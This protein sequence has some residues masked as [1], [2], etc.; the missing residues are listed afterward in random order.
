MGRCR[1]RQDPQL[2]PTPKAFQAQYQACVECVGAVAGNDED[3]EVENGGLMWL[4]DV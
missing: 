4:N 1:W 2:F 3:D